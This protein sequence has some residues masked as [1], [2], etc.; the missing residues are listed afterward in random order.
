MESWPDLSV[1]SKCFVFEE[2]T[3]FIIHKSTH[4][5]NHLSLKAQSEHVVLS[6]VASVFFHTVF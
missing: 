3:L 5:I 1:Q 4:L 6:L 2:H